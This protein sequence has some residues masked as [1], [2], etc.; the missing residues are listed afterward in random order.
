MVRHKMSYEPCGQFITR[1]LSRDKNLLPN[2]VKIQVTVSKA[3]RY[4]FNYAQ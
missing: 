3:S 4:L 1:H 2:R